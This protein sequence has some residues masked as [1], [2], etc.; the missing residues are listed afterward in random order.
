[1]KILA[2][3]TSGTVLSAAAAQNGKVLHEM[4]GDASVRPSDELVPMLEKLLKKTRWKPGALDA[5][6]VCVGPGSFTGIRVGVATAKM[7]GLVWK[8]KI[9]AVSS[10]EAA[11]YASDRG[12]KI[13]VA[14]DARRGNIYAAVYEKNGGSLRASTGP[15]LTTAQEFLEKTGSEAAMQGPGA[16]TAANVAKAA[17]AHAKHGK[18]LTA[19]KLEPLYLQPKDCNVTQ[20]KR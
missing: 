1:M 9:A 4:R 3:D 12:G 13:A 2:F 14:L 20:K 15:V 5:L 10:L 18:L 11:A 19:E 17:F 8:K 16:V 7:L 6:A